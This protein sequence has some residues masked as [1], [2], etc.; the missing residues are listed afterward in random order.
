MTLRLIVAALALGAVPPLAAQ[1]GTRQGVQVRLGGRVHPQ[2]NS[3]SVTAEPR[4]EMLIRRAR[5]TVDASW[6]WISARVEPDVGE[7][8]LN[9]KDA[10]AALDFGDALRVR[11]GQ[12]KRPFDVFELTSSTEM[13]VIERAGGI[14]G[15]NACAGPGGVCSF[16][17]LTERLGY[18]DR[19]IGV[20]LTG[21]AG[22]LDWS[23]AM[24]NGTGAN[25]ED[26]NGAKSFTGRVSGRVGGNLAI[27]ANVG[28]HD[29]V[30]P[31]GAADEY[32][33]ALGGDLQYGEFERGLV[34]QIGF[35]TGDNWRVPV[36]TAGSASFMTAQAIVAWAIPMTGERLVGIQ[37]VARL[38][39]ADPNSD[40]AGDSGM[41]LT[42][43]LNF[44]FGHRN[45]LTVNLDVW[46]PNTGDTEYSVKV[47]QFFYF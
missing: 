31:T 24:T 28:A 21:N 38:S 39:W 42:P 41:L 8:E 33:I 15:V 40:A 22:G 35:V 18:A 19:D 9:V 5:V 16:S 14:R 3:T 13:L 46:V 7:G 4:N 23:A 6:G 11:F 27:A 1:V 37:P 44:L 26:E 12:F 47:Q 34:L 25:V 20:E 2:Y 29:Y 10:W 43:G 30:H 17:R 32:A 45:K 36:G